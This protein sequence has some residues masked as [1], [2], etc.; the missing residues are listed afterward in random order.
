[1]GLGRK[2][3]KVV[4]YSRNRLPHQYLCPNCGKN[5]IMVIV[6][7]DQ[8]VARIF[9]SNCSLKREI[10]VIGETAPIDAYCQ[11]IDRFYG[12]EETQEQ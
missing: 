10:P 2:R 11:F 9:C 3:K 8:E 1:M 5:S 12:V 6:R 7:E 4:R